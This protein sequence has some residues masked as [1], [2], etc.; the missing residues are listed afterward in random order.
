MATLWLVVLF[1]NGQPTG[2]RYRM[3]YETRFTCED[4]K[5]LLDLD[6][7]KVVAARDLKAKRGRLRIETSCEMGSARI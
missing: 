4:A 1:L 3:D 2:L 7:I 6:Q 5:S